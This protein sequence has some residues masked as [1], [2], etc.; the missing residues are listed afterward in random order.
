MHCASTFCF[1]FFPHHCVC[2]SLFLLSTSDLVGH[3]A[4]HDARRERQIDTPSMHPDWMYARFWRQGF[5]ELLWWGTLSI[6][7]K[8]CGSTF[9]RQ[10]IVSHLLP[11]GAWLRKLLAGNIS[12]WQEVFVWTRGDKKRENKKKKKERKFDTVLQRPVALSYIHFWLLSGFRR[13]RKTLSLKE[14]RRPV[15]S[16]GVCNGCA[17][18]RMKKRHCMRPSH[19]HFGI[20]RGGQ[21]IDQPRP[22][23]YWNLIESDSQNKQ[24][25]ITM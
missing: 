12:T 23:W 15:A 25:F 5:S 16:A 24:M 21:V 17:F 19:H 8:S 10:N 9:M 7:A 14:Q 18:Y 22:A 11:N 13:L 4:E 1:L 20:I 6:V 2:F 3:R